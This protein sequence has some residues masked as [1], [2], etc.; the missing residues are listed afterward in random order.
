MGE[1]GENTRKIKNAKLT[2]WQCEKMAHNEKEMIGRAFESDN[3]MKENLQST[4]E[5]IPILVGY[6]LYSVEEG[7]EI[8][9]HI[10]AALRIIKGRNAKEVTNRVAGLSVRRIE[11]KVGGEVVEEEKE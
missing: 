10:E 5:L 3:A 8:A 2:K 9:K 6:G 4:A 11:N 7:V 1:F